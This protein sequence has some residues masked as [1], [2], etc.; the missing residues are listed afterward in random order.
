ML[1]VTRLLNIWIRCVVNIIENGGKGSSVSKLSLGCEYF[2]FASSCLLESMEARSIL[3]LSSKK[4]HLF[5]FAVLVHLP[6]EAIWPF[7]KRLLLS[8]F[9]WRKCAA[10][11]RLHF[12]V[13]N[14]HS[15]VRRLRY[16]LDL[17]LYQVMSQ[18]FRQIDVTRAVGPFRD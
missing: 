15:R 6:D 17:T 4:V 1:C 11:V 18:K 7:Q 3:R 2:S 8:M 5:E 13:R 16:Y 10:L 9:V 14:V 12:P